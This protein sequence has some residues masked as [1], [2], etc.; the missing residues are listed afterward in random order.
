MRTKLMSCIISAALLGVSQAG[1]AT[2][3]GTTADATGIDGL[4]VDGNTY[5][6]T[7]VN[8]SY[9]LCMWRFHRLS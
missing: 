9:D 8:G 4:I 3:V 5:D 6:V 7:F 2:L 1:A